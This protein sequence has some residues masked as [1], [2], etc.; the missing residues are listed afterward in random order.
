MT[1][2]AFICYKRN[3]A[4]DFATHLKKGLEEAGIPAFLDI[5]DIP[6]KFAGTQEWATTR[7]NAINESKYF[8]F[9]ITQSFDI[10]T[11]IKKELTMARRS[12]DKQF[13]YFRHADLS[14]YL[15]ID[16]DGQVL[17]LGKQQ[18]VIFN[19]KHELL[20]NAITVIKEGKIPDAISSD[21]ELFEKQLEDFDLMEKQSSDCTEGLA[22]IKS[23]GYWQI[24]IRPTKFQ[25]ERIND[26]SNG[27]KIIDECKLSFRSGGYPLM[28][29]KE[30]AYF[31]IDYIESI[32]DLSVHKELW[33]FYDSG[34]FIHFIGFKED[35]YDENEFRSNQPVCP[36]KTIFDAID[37]I[38]YMTE[39]YR[40]ASSLANKQVFDSSIQISIKLNELTNRALISSDFKRSLYPD[41]RCRINYF[42]IE[43]EI[44]LNELVEKCDEIAIEQVIEIFKRFG[45]HDPPVKGIKEI[46]QNFLEGRF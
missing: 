18:Q 20:R 3:T 38:Y 8:I 32:V 41:Y 27:L 40:F 11:E 44:S 42:P 10:S 7:D 33:R 34:Q 2:Q 9:I 6:E 5:T 15:T 4:E 25:K 39:I 36:P 28:N 26:L 16:L 43:K 24:I 45:L 35:W 13:I 12:N 14:S 1:Y 19:T 46:Q 21:K 37:A 23:R 31:G 22:K 30:Q 29:I 17:D